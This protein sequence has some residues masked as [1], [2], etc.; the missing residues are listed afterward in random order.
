VGLPGFAAYFKHNSDEEREHATKLMVQQ[1]RRGGRVQ[2][3]VGM[4]TAVSIQFSAVGAAVPLWVAVPDGWMHCPA[5]HT[6]PRVAVRKG[7]SHFAPH[8]L[9]TDI[10]V[11]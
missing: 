4:A 11:V 6:L 7:A 2:L 3:K 1:S 8:T 5:L 9:Q 10:N